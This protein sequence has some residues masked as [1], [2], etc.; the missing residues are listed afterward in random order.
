MRPHVL[1]GIDV[2]ASHTHRNKFVHELYHSVPN[3]CQPLVQV[4]PI[5]D[6]TVPHLVSISRV[7]NRAGIVKIP[8]TVR[9][10]RIILHFRIRHRTSGPPNRPTPTGHVV[11]NHFH[12]NAHSPVVAR[13]HHRPELRLVTR[14][15]GNLVR[16]R[17]IPFAPR[18]IWHNANLVHRGHLDGTE[19]VRTKVRQTFRLDIHVGPLEKLHD[20]G[21]FLFGKMRIK[22]TASLDR[23]N[24]H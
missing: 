17:F 1:S 14:S 15:A 7:N 3:P 4:R 9:R 22:L 21:G 24:C 8:S 20:S 13:A 2:K 10:C 12:V 6:L 23:E 19:P 11:Q 18:S 16:N 5:V